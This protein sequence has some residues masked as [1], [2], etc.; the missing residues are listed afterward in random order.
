MLWRSTRPSVTETLVTAIGRP[1]L[2][3]PFPHGVVV[4]VHPVGKFSHLFY[5]GH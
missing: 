4:P 5:G 3:P 1:N 2:G